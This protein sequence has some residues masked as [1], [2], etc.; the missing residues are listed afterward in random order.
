VFES[1]TTTETGTYELRSG[2]GILDAFAVNVDPA[3]SDLRH[4]TNEELAAFWKHVGVDEAQAHRVHASDKLETTVLE[5]RLGV[6]LWKYSLALAII[7]ALVEMAVGRE[8]KSATVG[9]RKA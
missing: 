8:S 9:D 4:A 5:S 6:E 7:V 3:E 2:N 1:S